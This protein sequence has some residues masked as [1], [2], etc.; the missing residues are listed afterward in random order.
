LRYDEN[1]HL[2]ESKRI[3]SFG[4]GEMNR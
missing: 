4:R 3:K 2:L 1:G